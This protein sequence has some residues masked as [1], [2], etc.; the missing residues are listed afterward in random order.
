MEGMGNK[1][2][3]GKIPAVQFREVQIQLRSHWLPPF[4]EITVHPWKKTAVGLKVRKIGPE[5][6]FSIST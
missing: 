1:K 5:H 2:E 4:A 3:G 6:H